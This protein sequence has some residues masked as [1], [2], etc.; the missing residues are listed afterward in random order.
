[1]H[2]KKRV[3]KRGNEARKRLV[4]LKKAKKQIEDK[5]MESEPK[6]KDL[7]RVLRKLKKIKQK[8]ML[9]NRKERN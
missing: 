2:V 4:Q 9:L 5:A 3:Y 1:M 6:K 7:V 8:K